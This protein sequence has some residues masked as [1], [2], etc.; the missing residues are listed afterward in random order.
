M[1]DAP[2]ILLNYRAYERIFQKYVRDFE[3]TALGDHYLSLKS[4]WLDSGVME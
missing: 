1:E 3:G 2:V 4:I